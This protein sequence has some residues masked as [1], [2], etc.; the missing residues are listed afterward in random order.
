MSGNYYYV[1]E[2]SR[3]PILMALS[4]FLLVAGAGNYLNGLASGEGGGGWLLLLGLT[5]LILVLSSWFN[6]VIRENHASMTNALVKRSF[7]MAMAWFIFTEV[8]FFFAFFF[9]LFYV[10]LFSVEWIGG[11]GDKQYNT[12]LWPEFQAQW[13]LLVN[14]DTAKFASPDGIIDPWQI[15]LINTLLLLASSYTIHKAHHELLRDRRSLFN[16]WLVITLLFGFTFIGLQIYEYIHAYQDLGLTLNSG[17]YGTTFFL[18]TGFHGLH[19][20]LGGI[21]LLVMLLRS[22]AGHFSPNDH[23]GFQAASW[24]WHFVDVVWV[25]LFMFVYVL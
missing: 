8:M 18:L 4:M 7:V 14:P 9:A 13:P 23:F 19:V 11:G 17:I 15:P 21:M 1:P 3:I 20:T 24:Y 2:K 16:S 12:L 6:L 25:C 22:Y 10:R 5:S